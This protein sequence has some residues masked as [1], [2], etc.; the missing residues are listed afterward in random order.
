MGSGLSCHCTTPVPH[1]CFN[2]ALYVF[3]MGIMSEGPAGN[4]SPGGGEL[5]CKKDGD[6]FGN[7]K[8]NIKSY[9]DPV[10]WVWLGFFHS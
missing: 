1:K 10:L 4:L 7:F 2:V 5:L 6:T 8:S 9:Q 3:N